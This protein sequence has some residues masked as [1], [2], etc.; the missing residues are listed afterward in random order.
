MSELRFDVP[1]LVY[2]NYVRSHDEYPQKNQVLQKGCCFN[3]IAES[4]LIKRQ[5]Q[6]VVSFYLLYD[7]HNSYQCKLFSCFKITEL[8]R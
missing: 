7:Q 1:Y 2:L 4:G 6:P 8:I 5:V 3:K